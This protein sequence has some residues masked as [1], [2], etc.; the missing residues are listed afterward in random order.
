MQRS[1][2]TVAVPVGLATG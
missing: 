2:V 1:A